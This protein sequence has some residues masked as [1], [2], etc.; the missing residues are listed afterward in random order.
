M[1]KFAILGYGFMGKKHF[2]AIAQHPDAEVSALIDLNLQHRPDLGHYQGLD[3]FLHDSPLADVVI[4]ATPNARH[5]SEAEILLNRGYNVLVE[6][7]YCLSSQEADRLIQTAEK[8]NKNL[9]LAHQNRHSPISKFLKNILSENQLGKIYFVQTNLLWSRDEKYYQKGSWKG[10]KTQDGGTLYT[11]FFHFI[12]LILWLFGEIEV[13]NA[14]AKTLRHNH[15]VE[16]E[17]TGTF[18][19]TLTETEGLGVVNFST[20]VCRKNLESSMTIIAEKGTLKISGQYF[21]RIEFCDIEGLEDSAPLFE[22]QGNPNNLVA[23]VQEI[24]KALQTAPNYA[25]AR[26]GLNVVKKIEAIY[27]C[28]S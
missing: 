12:D 26:K 15:L 28:L 13:Q 27:A 19:Y 20:A 6:K 22:L 16:I 8:Q 18:T 24:C 3:A 21:D 11:Q 25:E 2:D 1:T 23:S 17:D 7:P 14:T 9:F 4:I 10:T 5:C